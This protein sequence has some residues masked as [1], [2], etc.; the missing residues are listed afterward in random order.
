LVLVEVRLFGSLIAYCLHITEIDPLKHDLIFERFINLERM[1]MPDVD[2]DIQDNRR[3]EVIR[4]L[5]ERY[6]K[7]R[8]AQI[9]TF[10]VMKARLAVRDVARALGFPYS[11][12]DKIAKLIPFNMSAEEA[13][14]KVSELKEL[15]DTD[16]QAKEIL[17]ISQKL[18]GV[19]RHASTHA[20]GVV[21]TPEKLTD[22]VPLQHSSRNEEEIITQYNMYDLEKSV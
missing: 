12:G 15:Y 7:D 3:E 20:A 21:I 8:V 4:Y 10:G 1:E 18:E 5:E 14:K 22:Y 16:L 6:G 11:L 13:L 17:D 19:A 2:T 9:L